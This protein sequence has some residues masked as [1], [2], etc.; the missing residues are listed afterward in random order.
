[1]KNFNKLKLIRIALFVFPHFLLLFAFAGNGGCANNVLTSSAGYYG[2][3]EANSSNISFT[4]AGSD[5]YNGLPRNGSYQIVQNVSQLGGGGYLNIQPR[6]G[7]YFLASHTSNN[8]NERVWYANVNVIPGA[9]YQFCAAVTLLKNLGGGAD[10]ELGLYANGVSIAQTRVTFSWTDMCGSFTVPA[11]VTNIELSIRDPKKGLFFVAIDDICLTNTSGK[12]KLGNQV[13]NDYDGDGKRDLDEPGIANV[14]VTL[15][16]DDNADNLPDAGDPVAVTTT[17]LY[18]KYQFSNLVAGSYIASIPVLAGYSPSPNTS[19]QATSPTPDNDVDNDNNLVR[20]SGGN[21]FTNAITLT[22]NG[23]PVTDGDDANGNLTLDMGECGNSFIG[24]FVWNDLNN[25]GIQDSSEPGINGQTVT[26]IF[27]DG[28]IAETQTLNYKGRDGYYDFKNLGPGTY[29]IAFTTPAGLTPT[30][31]NVGNDSTDSD[32]V[33]G[34]ATVTIAANQSDFTIDAGFVQV[35]PP[36]SNLTLG[37]LVWEDTNNNGIKD[38]QES[39]MAGVEV[40][41][42]LDDNAD[43]IADGPVVG[44]MLTDNNGN[45]NFIGLPAGKY[46][47]GATMPYGYVAP[48][49]NTASPDNNIDNDNNAAVVINGEARSRYI[50]LLQNTEPTTDGDD[51]NG[52][53]TLDFAMQKLSNSGGGNCA[54]TT[55][56]YGYFG[57]FESGVNNF[58]TFGAVTDLSIGLPRNGS[59]EVVSNVNN[60]GGGGYLNIQSYDGNNFMLIHTSSNSNDR[61]WATKISVTPGQIYN[62]CA[63]IA[64]AKPTPINGF[65]L[66]LLANNTVIATST[67]VFGW[68]QIC[69][70]YTVPAGVT[71]VEFSIKDPNP[72]YGP[73]HFLALDAICLGTSTP[74]HLD[75]R[76]AYTGGASTKVVTVEKAVLP[77]SPNPASTSFTLFMSAQSKGTANIRIINTNGKTVQTA[78]PRLLKGTNSYTMNINSDIAGG[79]YYVVINIDGATH[80]QP[81]MIAR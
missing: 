36:P 51:A 28:T 31:S 25:N 33:N 9:T 71:S 38:P 56:A 43:N 57:G 23:E 48:L 50:T 81:L 12:L 72:G 19:T 34:S 69:G 29:T 73:S 6:S 58:G 13:W 67:A 20:V 61:L 59:Y 39:G 21:I 75:G 32:P 40:R 76:T 22:E 37:N 15:Y 27:A 45:Y 55:N 68:T 30:P 7:N 1:M 64:N 49:L 10:Y 42:Y 2:G 44:Y 17:D 11:G 16:K 60:A 77:I 79:M 5:L 14:P 35:P 78:N 70:S 4:T 46:I 54:A 47:V 3:F 26:I 65:T 62:F 41:L 8:L 18:G 74:I 53:Q 63:W 66:N 24:D 52:N 80:T